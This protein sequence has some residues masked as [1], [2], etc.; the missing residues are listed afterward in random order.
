MESALY[1]G[2]AAQGLCFFHVEVQEEES[3]CGYLKFLDNYTVMIIE[4]GEIEVVEIIEK[5]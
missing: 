2:S 4:E 1:L 5:W 3:R